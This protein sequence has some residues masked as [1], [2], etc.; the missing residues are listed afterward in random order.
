MDN[1]IEKEH[2]FKGI[3]PVLVTPF[4]EQLAIDVGA[5]REIIQWH[6]AHQVGGIYANCLSSEMYELDEKEKLLLVEEAVKT[7]NGKIPVAA[8]GNFGSTIEEH[9]LF[10]QKVADAGAD[11][12]MLTVPTFCQDD[13]AL[14]HY[15]LSMAEKTDMPLGIYEC[16]VP[17]AYHL[18]LDLIREI[19]QS[20]RYYAYKET[21]CDINK[22]KKI[23][24]IT[25]QSALALLQANVPHLLAAVKAGA[26]GSMNIVA[27][28]L[29]DLTVEVANRGKAGDSTAEEL[30]A[31][32]CMMELAQRSIHPTGVKYLMSK[33]GLPIKPLTRYP[34]SLTQEE[35]HSLDT[36]SK[37]WFETDG[38][39]KLLKEMA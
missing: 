38:S 20:G 7:A 32:L 8:T 4:D 28:W 2:S 21:S 6:M 24:Q 10:C 36:I 33:R 34:K 18:G 13:Q 30:H 16:P 12:V 11:L 22:I 31:V 19:A 17:R 23:I 9:L 35:A 3:W 29:P 15:Y 1:F 39:L 26:A 27:N 14:A 25:Q 5:Y 37:M